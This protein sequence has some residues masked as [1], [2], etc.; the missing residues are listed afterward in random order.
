[1]KKSLATRAGP[2]RTAL[3]FTLIEVLL[4]LAV[5]AGMVA[6]LF[7]ALARARDRA[8][9]LRCHHNLRQLRPRAPRAGEPVGR[10]L[11]ELRGRLDSEAVVN[12]ARNL[13]PHP[14]RH[15]PGPHRDHPSNQD[16]VMG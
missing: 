10:R 13:H 8:P 15:G 4:V 14:A 16:D 2:R 5:L 1:M 12:G 7:P 6:L 9:S 11:A 3:G